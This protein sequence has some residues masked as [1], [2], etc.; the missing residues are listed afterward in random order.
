MSSRS[1]CWTSIC[2]VLIT[3]SITTAAVRINGN[4]LVEG[5]GS[6]GAF[7]KSLPSA[8]APR[9]VFNLG[10]GLMARGELPDSV[11]AEG[12][13]TSLAI[14]IGLSYDIAQV[15]YNVFCPVPLT[16]D[17]NGDHVITAADILLLIAYTFRSA[18][19]VPVCAAAGDVNCS[20]DVT[21]ADCVYLI[22]YVFQGGP[23]PCDV[24]DLFRTGIWSCPQ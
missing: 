17:L 12:G 22:N 20:G 4:Q 7:N 19:L 15:S 9:I 13:F 16:G 2:L 6:F 11:Q 1:V 21:S 3:A 23:P 18:K 14:G 5:A 8:G 24:C 10:Q